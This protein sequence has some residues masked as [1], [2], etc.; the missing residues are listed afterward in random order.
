MTRWGGAWALHFACADP[1]NLKELSIQAYFEAPLSISIKCADLPTWFRRVGTSQHPT[2]NQRFLPCFRKIAGRAAR[3]ASNVPMPEASPPAA[4]GDSPQQAPMGVSSVTGP[5]PNKG[6]EAAVIQR[7]GGM[8]NTLTELLP[9][10]GATSEMGNMIMDT[11]KKFSKHVPPG[12]S[13][14]ASER[15]NLQQQMMRNQQNMA[16]EQQMRGGGQQQPQGQPQGG[17]PMQRAA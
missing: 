17:A 2:P 16:M 10:V 15:N 8:I 3:V 5:T 7:L 6:F 12:A 9:M 4:G 14:P 13:S 1:N 11:I